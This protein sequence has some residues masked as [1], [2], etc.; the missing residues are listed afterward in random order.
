MQSYQVNQMLQSLAKYIANEEAISGQQGEDGGFQYTQGMVYNATCEW[1]RKNYYVWSNWIPRDTC[2]AGNY[3]N[4]R[5]NLCSECEQGKFKQITSSATACSEC[6]VGKFA[7]NNGSSSCDACSEA[8][9][10][11]NDYMIPYDSHPIDMHPNPNPNPNL[12]PN[13]RA[14]TPH[15]RAQSSVLSVPRTLSDDLRAM[16]AT[17]RNASAKQVTTTAITLTPKVWCISACRARRVLTAL[18]ISVR[19]T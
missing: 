4:H 6:Q 18:V 2:T 16:A 17:Y 11:L 5:D 15:K 14:N 9:T 10:C 12:N 19:T 1:L 8:K 13:R 3:L 7:I